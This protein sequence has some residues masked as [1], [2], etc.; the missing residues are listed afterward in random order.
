MEKSF[1]EELYKNRSINSLI[2]FS[3][4][5]VIEGDENKSSSSPFA[6]ARENKEKCT[7]ERLAKE[8]FSLFPKAFSFSRYREW[9][10]SRKLDR[11]LRSLRRKKLISGDPKNYFSLTKLGKQI[12]GEMVKT[13]SQARLKL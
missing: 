7:F 10:D 3:I 12:A 2:L 8:C 13:L 11:P 4:Y 1:D 6:V 9:P 5:S